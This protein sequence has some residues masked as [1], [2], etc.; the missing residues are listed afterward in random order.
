MHVDVTQSK[1][2]CGRAKLNDATIC[3]GKR[4]SY[5]RDAETPEAVGHS[6]PARSARHLPCWELHGAHSWWPACVCVCVCMCVR[7]RVREC[8]RACV[9][10][11]VCVCVCVHACARVCVRACACVR[12]CMHVCVRVCVCACAHVCVQD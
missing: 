12:A 9:R 10:V 11:C 4:V 5:L 6:Q 1:R 2:T 7:M 8:V 3:E